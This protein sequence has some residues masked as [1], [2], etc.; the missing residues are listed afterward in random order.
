MTSEC[1]HAR[2]MQWVSLR[3]ARSICNKARL[4][5]VALPSRPV[6]ALTRPK[7]PPVTIPSTSLPFLP[8]QRRSIFTSPTR[9][10]PPP[11]VKPR[12][13]DDD[14]TA[15]ADYV[16]RL[17]SLHERFQSLEDVQ[18]PIDP[19][20]QHEPQPLDFPDPST[21]TIPQLPPKTRQFI[22]R[23][24][25]SQLI[26][27]HLPSNQCAVAAAQAVRIACRDNALPDAEYIVQSLIYSNIPGA[28][29]T[30][31]LELPVLGS[32][33]FVP[34]RFERPIS[35]RLAA[36]CLVHHHLRYGNVLKA[37]TTAERF[38]RDGVRIREATLEIL[39]TALLHA[40]P[41][42]FDVLRESGKIMLH[43][44]DVIGEGDLVINPEMIRSDGAR[45]ALV[46]LLKARENGQ[47]NSD[48]LLER[49]ASVFLLN[50]EI[51][52]GAILFAFIVRDFELRWQRAQALKAKLV[53]EEASLG[54]ASPDLQSSVAQ[55]V[56]SISRI[57]PMRIMKSI[58]QQCSD[59]IS[60][61]AV[62]EQGDSQQRADAYQAL[63]FLAN[64]VDSRSLPYSDISTL[65]R[66]LYSCPRDSNVVWVLRD[67]QWEMVNAYRYFH[68]VLYRLARRP[69]TKSKAPPIKHG[70][71]KDNPTPPVM[72]QLT[73]ETYNTLV[74]YALRH[75]MS[76]VM[77][78]KILQHMEFVRSPGLKPD[79][80]TYNIFLR[81]GT[82]LRQNGLVSHTLE[83][84]RMGKVNNGHGIMVLPQPLEPLQSSAEPAR[85]SHA[86]SPQTQEPKPIALSQFLRIRAPT[87]PL[88]A[89]ST[90]LVSYICHLTSTGRPDAVVD[91]LWY[92]LPEL[93]IVDHPAWDNVTP[94]HRA[95]MAQQTRQERLD[96]AVSLG[97]WF[98]TTVLN[99]LCKAGKTGLAERVWLLARQA[100]MASW[101]QADA[102][103][104]GRAVQGWCLP[105]HAYTIMLQVYA[106][107]AK[108]GIGWH[109]ARHGDNN[110]N[111]SSV[112]KIRQGWAQYIVYRTC[113]TDK[114]LSRRMWALRVGAAHYRSM[115]RG[116]RDIYNTLT[117][118]DPDCAPEIQVLQP[119]E[120]FFNAALDMFGRQT[121]MVK[122]SQRPT[123][124]Q[125]RWL[126]RRTMLRYSRFGVTPR[127]W[128]PFLRR[129]VHEMMNAGFA[130]PIGFRRYFV[131]TW[132]YGSLDRPGRPLRQRQPFRLCPMKRHP[133]RPYAVRTHK[134]RGLPISRKLWTKGMKRRMRRWWRRKALNGHREK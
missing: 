92:I 47:R 76:I 40:P 93:S 116:A 17:L 94:E 97:P 74:H 86:S 62:P 79:I 33:D 110:W 37:K 83:E 90:T 48:R 125:W 26:K 128:N 124:S 49:F 88:T 1:R 61:D 54:A 119:D 15:D 120:R 131:D 30:V 41:T 118:W 87:R 4:Q 36:H 9:L 80:T 66:A 7:I 3:A 21:T 5:S 99:A 12:Y 24:P 38:L 2:H 11:E 67:G 73:R 45:F 44:I 106:K 122:R 18:D 127:K 101:V 43:Q 81:S 100:E 98:F 58:V 46:L 6:T 32:F 114:R 75:R 129:I 126:N 25:S 34:I 10:S 22:L 60:V 57:P 16:D 65:L 70:N 115:W 13:P 113:I 123:P 107:E 63:A 39:A 78:Q 51:L 56:S 103:G 55:A 53:E 42:T 109:P 130:V 77:A 112:E 64:L 20:L 8:I 134:T 68:D 91:V 23:P 121:C 84:L 52:L 108:K 85:V 82:L 69:P 89:D 95:A 28:P 59:E 133:F 19:Y 132:F 31:S 14:N 96:R 29:E 102:S 35:P 72:P 27:T 104:E 50:G 117:R 105:V 111:P 71:I